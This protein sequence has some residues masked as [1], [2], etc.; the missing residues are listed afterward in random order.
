MNMA[1]LRSGPVSKCIYYFD[2]LYNG[3][4]YQIAIKKIKQDDTLDWLASFQNRFW[5][6][7]PVIDS[8][9]EY[10]Y[11]ITGSIPFDVLRINTTSGALVSAAEL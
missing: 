8:N 5:F 10:L 9:E 3:T 2:D 1:T 7:S 11:F 6:E 4:A